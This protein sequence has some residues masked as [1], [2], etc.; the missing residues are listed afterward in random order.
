MLVR[1]SFSSSAYA[2]LRKMGALLGVASDAQII[3][4]ALR[5]FQWYL[6]A[7]AEGYQLARTKDG[8]SFTVVDLDFST[9]AQQQDASDPDPD[10]GTLSHEERAL[11]ESVPPAGLPDIRLGPRQRRLAESLV[12]KGVLRKDGIT[13]FPRIAS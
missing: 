8:L 7:K 1:L 9:G 10:S 3:R 2:S 13:Y 12:T 5:F 4:H 11:L 6:Q